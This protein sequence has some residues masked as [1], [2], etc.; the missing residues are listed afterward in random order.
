MNGNGDVTDD[1]GRGVRNGAKPCI[2]T[3]TTATAR[4]T[5]A[6]LR[7]LD[8]DR[9]RRHVHLRRAGQRHLLGGRRFADAR[10]PA[11]RLGGADLRRRRGHRR[12]SDLGGRSTAGATP[13]SPTTHRRSRRA[14]H[15]TRVILA[16]A[17]VAGVDSGFSFNAV[18]SRATA[19]TTP[20]IRTARSRAA[21]ASSSRTRTRRRRA[22]RELL[23]R[24]GGLGAVDR[25]HR[26]R[27]AGDHRYGDAR[28]VDAGRPATPARRSSSSNGGGVGQRDDGFLIAPTAGGST[29]RGFVINRF[30]GD[31]IHVEGSDS[32]HRRQLHRH[33]L[34]HHGS[35]ATAP[36]VHTS[37]DCNRVGGTGPASAT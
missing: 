10:R 16:G 6:T 25:A 3:S 24:R 14:E 13:P 30:Q 18:T 19:T 5:R 28:R 31:G 15:V 1:G 27:A 7:R 37:S 36:G 21:C 26:L 8:V 29:V 32:D 33:R 12:R 22:G 9:R 11:E 23:D 2:S 35:W 20:A 17:D 34:G 4:S